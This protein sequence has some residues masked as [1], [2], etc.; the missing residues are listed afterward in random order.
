MKNKYCLLPLLASLPALFS[1]S[2]PA[3]APA[4]SAARV[5]P[6]MQAS[7]AEDTS[8]GY[9]KLGR[10]Y[11]G[12]N[13][14]EQA[15]EAYR[16]AIGLSASYVDAHN[17]LGTVYSKQGKFDEAIAEL[18]TALQIVP[19]LARVYNNLG[20]TYYLQSN[21]AEAVVAY[22]K[23]IALEPGNPR[24]YNNLGVAYDKL[25][26]AEKSRLA[27]QRAEGLNL[28][29]ATA[30]NEKLPAPAPASL[31]V[32][33][34]TRADVANAPA[35]ISLAGATVAYQLPISSDSISLPPLSLGNDG[36]FGSTTLAELPTPV[37]LSQQFIP[38][39][40]PTLGSLSKP[41]LAR[42]ALLS[43][44][45]DRALGKLF[46]AAAESEISYPPASRPEQ[47]K[48]YRLEIANG[49]GVTG[50]ATKVRKTLVSQG[51]PV[52]RL[53]NIK[54]YQ[55]PQTLIQYRAGYQEQALL[56]GKKFLKTPRL[57][58]EEH[59]RSSSDL[60]LVL[61]KDV[62]NRVALFAPDEEETMRLAYNANAP[63]KY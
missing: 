22:E 12:Q 44:K 41:E 26:D 31:A 42:P 5:E 60:R 20:Y 55:E 54:P 1:C 43:V 4:L 50:L 63:T 29:A 47:A 25:G 30:N 6:L 39:P 13:R 28:P 10:F 18:S 59:L 37:E 45:F 53:T 3:T 36:K 2:T 40:E 9:Y 35:S 19:D 24:T 33:L 17:A 7:G 51:L 48:A 57:V 61:G 16:K 23:A 27:F 21:F 62:V 58:Q 11:Q 56:L 52:A 14:L 15:A 34:V 49:N 32:E 8:L 46:S 38:P